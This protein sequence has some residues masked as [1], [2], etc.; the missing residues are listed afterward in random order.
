MGFFNAILMLAG[1]GVAA[2]SA[3]SAAA[4]RRPWGRPW[5]SQRNARTGPPSPPSPGSPPAGSAF[6][7]A[8][9]SP[10]QYVERGGKVTR[11]Q[12]FESIE[13]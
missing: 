1:P 10:L 3:G 6:G 4:E 11:A 13:V 5:G 2:D 8:Q 9:G 7:S 12:R